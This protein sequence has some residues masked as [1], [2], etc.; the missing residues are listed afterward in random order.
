M[1]TQGRLLIEPT[2]PF[3]AVDRDEIRV[4]LPENGP[5]PL[6][7]DLL[8][9]PASIVDRLLD[10][11]ALERT[12]L[13]SLSAIA[14]GT[15]AFAVMLMAPHGT[16]VALRASVL[17]AA[18]MLIAL[19][20]ALGPIW[21]S[22][23]LVSARL[24]LSRLVGSLVTSAATGALILAALAPLPH[25]CQKWDPEWAGPLS[26]VSC[27]AF[28]GIAAGKRIHRTLLILAERI[29]KARSDQP[30]DPAEIHRVKMLAERAMI[31]FSF[32][33]ALSVWGFDAFIS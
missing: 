8:G 4:G 7:L 24:P 2:S 26:V 21:A 20:A 29:K 32:T 19:A 28:A 31:F 33:V 22:G 14:L 27:F 15:A 16:A 30:L 23:L 25:L 6:L 11:D 3:V 1:V 13:G 9:S 12:L 18:N 10:P 5:S 17:A